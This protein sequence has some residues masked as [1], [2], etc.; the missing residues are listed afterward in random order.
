MGGLERD[1]GSSYVEKLLGTG[2]QSFTLP[3]GDHPRVLCAGVG[4]GGGHV[5]LLRCGSLICVS[6]TA[7]IVSASRGP[8]M[9][10][11][12]SDSCV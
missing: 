4:K 5:F 10:N 2:T 3:C 9:L 1:P 7:Y 6:V 11:S 12:G 8:W